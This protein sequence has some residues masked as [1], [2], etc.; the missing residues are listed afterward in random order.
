MTHENNFRVQERATT[1][2]KKKMVGDWLPINAFQEAKYIC[3][4]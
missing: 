1:K 2:K 4:V 3:V